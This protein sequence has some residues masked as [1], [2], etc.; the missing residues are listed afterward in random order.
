MAPSATTNQRYGFPH[1][2]LHRGDLHGI[3]VDA[4][5]SLKPNAIHLARRCDVI[6]SDEH[7]EVRFETGEIVRP[8]RWHSLEDSGKPV[9]TEPTRVHR[10]C[11]VARRRADAASSRRCRNNGFHELARPARPSLALSHSRGE[12]TNFLSMVERDDWQ[13]ESWT[14]QS[15]T[16]VRAR[17][18]GLR[19]SRDHPPGAGCLRC[20]LSL[21]WR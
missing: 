1:V 13:V 10:L 20:S 19:R 15:T 16:S 18:L 12:L 3:L 7:V 9:W 5:R 11:C 2:L 17:T 4:V 21:L 6:Q 14:V 8:S